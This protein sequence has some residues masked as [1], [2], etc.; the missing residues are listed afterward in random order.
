MRYSLSMG[1]ICGYMDPATPTMA[2][3]SGGACGCCG[4]GGGPDDLRR[5]R[6]NEMLKRWI[7]NRTN[8][9]SFGT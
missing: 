7:S 4:G 6:K 1:L 2:G 9:D 3:T 8:S 5:R